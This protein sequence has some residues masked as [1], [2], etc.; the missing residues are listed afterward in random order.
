MNAAHFPIIQ[1]TAQY[2]G[3]ITRWPNILMDTIGALTKATDTE[4]T[5]STVNEQM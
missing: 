4:D 2:S 3:G 1:L 5:D